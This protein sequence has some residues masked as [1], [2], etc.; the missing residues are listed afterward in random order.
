MLKDNFG[1]LSGFFR[2]EKI[3]ED[4]ILITVLVATGFITVGLRTLKEIKKNERKKK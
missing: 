1:H 3:M 2:K 4:F